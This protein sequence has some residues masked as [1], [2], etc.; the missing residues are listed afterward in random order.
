ML[1]LAMWR[2]CFSWASLALDV[3]PPQISEGSFLVGRGF[4]ASFTDGLGF[5]LA[6]LL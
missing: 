5:E 6:S 2:F 4:L 3:H 1:E